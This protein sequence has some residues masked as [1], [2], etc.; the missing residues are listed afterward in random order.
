MFKMNRNKKRAIVRKNAK[1]I[2]HYNGEP[3]Q[4]RLRQICK[5]FGDVI[6]CVDIGCGNGRSAKVLRQLYPDASIISFDKLPENIDYAS[7]SVRDANTEFITA[8][9]FGF[10]RDATDTKYDLALFSWS[11]FDMSNEPDFGEREKQLA[12]LL[13]MVKSCLS[14]HGAILVLQPSKGGSFEK[15]LSKFNPG[16]DDDYTLVHRFL[17]KQGFV[18]PKDIFP[19][20]NDPLAIWSCFSYGS[21]DDVYYG[22]ASIE[23]LEI[24]EDLS[25]EKFKSIFDE[26]LSENSLDAD[27]PMNFSDCVNIYYYIKGKDNVK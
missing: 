19:S 27:Y 25:R 11:L 12:L 9:A 8:D 18:G 20:K 21:E 22:I 3:E 26:Y 23:K 15:L 16:S 7:K 14:E 1:W 17:L 13:S 24:N 10:F 6:T 2:T 5:H 4:V